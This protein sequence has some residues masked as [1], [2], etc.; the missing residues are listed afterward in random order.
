MA[1]ELV[2]GCQRVEDNRWLNKAS[3][4]SAKMNNL[5]FNDSHHLQL[6][7]VQKFSRKVTFAAIIM[8]YLEMHVGNWVVRG[9]ARATKP[10]ELLLR[11]I[12]LG[13]SPSFSVFPRE[14]E[15]SHSSGGVREA[16]GREATSPAA[17]LA[18]FSVDGGRR[19]REQE[20]ELTLH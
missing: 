6:M 14:I 2:Q 3:F 20:N 8:C 12:L 1:G 10:F 4:H 7:S 5:P 11:R 9:Q 18:P 17:A 19:Q 13:L 16:K 15:Y